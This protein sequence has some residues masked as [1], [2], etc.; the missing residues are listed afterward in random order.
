[1]WRSRAV[2]LGTL[3]G[4]ALAGA[5]GLSLMVRGS[6]SNVAQCAKQRHDNIVVLPAGGARD[7]ARHWDSHAQACPFIHAS[8]VDISWVVA[9]TCSCI[10]A[11]MLVS[12]PSCL[13]SANSSV[14]VFATCV[15]Q[16]PDCPDPMRRWLHGTHFSIL[17]LR[18]HHSAAGRPF[19]HVIHDCRL[20]FPPRL[21][22]A[23]VCAQARDPAQETSRGRL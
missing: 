6:E 8:S 4:S 16:R 3:G 14:F 2:R 20:T 5:A 15:R 22:D 10:P 7:L 12:A 9:H 21:G 1:M 19:P 18:S 11:C 23:V 17:S 13:K